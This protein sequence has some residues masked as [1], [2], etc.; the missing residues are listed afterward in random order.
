M[1]FTTMQSLLIIYLYNLRTRSYE[2]IVE[3]M[4]NYCDCIDHYCLNSI[5]E[6][7]EGLIAND[8]IEELEDDYYKLIPG[9]VFYKG[10]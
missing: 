9:S 7:L 10:V 8:I 1:K 5:Q 2:E 4:K 3:H 6:S